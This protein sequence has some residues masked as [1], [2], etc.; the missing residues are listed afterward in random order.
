[1]ADSEM[2]KKDIKNGE[3][4]NTKNT[5]NTKNKENKENKEKEMDKAPV[6]APE[7]EKA[8]KAKPGDFKEI[9]WN[10]WLWPLTALVAICLVTSLLLAVVNNVTAPIIEEN[11]M[12]IAEETRKRLLPEADGF[13]LFSE[14]GGYGDGIKAVYTATNGTGYIIEAY[15]KG[16]GGDVPV[17]VAFS[18]EGKI[19]GIEFGQ[20]DE[21][22]GLG[23]KLYTDK[24]F[25]NQFV[26]RGNESIVP[27]DIDKIASATIST[28]AGILAVNRA[29]DF[30]N[31][32]IIGGGTGALS[33]DQIRTLLF[34]GA[35]MAAPVDLNMENIREAW[36]GDN[37]NYVIYG[38]APGFYENKTV[39]AAVGMTE[40]GEITG[41]WLDTSSDT[42]GL[43]SEVGKNQNFMESFTGKT[44][45]EG[46][47]AV[48]G[49]TVTSTAV[50]NAVETALAALPEAKTVEAGEFSVLPALPL[51]KEERDAMG[52]E[53]ILAWLLPGQALKELETGGVK[54]YRGNHGNYIV[55][56]TAPGFYQKD[57]TA[58]VAVDENGDIINLWL[59]TAADTEGLGQEIQYNQP[60]VNSFG[61]L[62][63]ASVDS[64]DTVA[65]A[66]V[67]SNGAKEAVKNALANF[68]IVKEAG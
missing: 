16:Y 3:N 63:E 56:G 11:D 36:F 19:S 1:M 50:F 26:G 18:A 48:A 8:N 55:Y 47:D 29:I 64:V 68:S 22:P 52:E 60:F 32:N 27:A 53:E 2:N 62:N 17:T 37:G 6:F 65:E 45:T 15:A 57:I 21:T 66:T 43:G 24:R 39:T 44:S 42:E 25:G 28:N 20:N 4:E 9:Y 54:A 40:T 58:I 7:K 13:A 14:S 31:E 59:D 10:P 51:S 33:P 41:I 38:T 46:I 49:A 5:K 34:A 30:L 61:G 23:Q 67:T 35:T 12:R